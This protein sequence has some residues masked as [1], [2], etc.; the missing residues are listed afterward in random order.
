MDEPETEQMETSV[1]DE[2]ERADL[3]I[4]E[5]DEVAEVE[6]SIGMESFEQ[7]PMAASTPQTANVSSCQK[8]VWYIFISLHFQKKRVS[9]KFQSFM[10]RFDQNESVICLTEQAEEM[11][12]TYDNDDIDIE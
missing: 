9:F 6:V 8:L 1:V 2:V 12:N 3:D 4:E 5:A 10:L 7:A 11:F